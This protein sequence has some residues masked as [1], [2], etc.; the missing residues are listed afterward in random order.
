MITLE[1]D[2]KSVVQSPNTLS[3]VGLAGSGLAVLLH[4]EGAASPQLLPAAAKWES[5]PQVAKSWCFSRQT[6]N[7]AKDTDVIMLVKNSN[8]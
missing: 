2:S 4:P 1:G 8:F 6:R 3:S 7:L 5:G